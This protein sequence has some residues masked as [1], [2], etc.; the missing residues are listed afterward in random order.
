MP[1]QVTTI[2]QHLYLGLL[3]VL[4]SSSAISSPTDTTPT[5]TTQAKWQTH[6]IIFSDLIEAQKGEASFPNIYIFN[7]QSKLVA[8]ALHADTGLFKQF[9]YKK[10][11]QRPLPITADIKNRLVMLTPLVEALTPPK[12]F[13][14]VLL[15]ADKSLVDCVACRNVLKDLDNKLKDAPEDKFDLLLVSVVRN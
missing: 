10:I 8:I 11:S 4:F 14:V 6:T 9:D 7:Q 13:T 3:L 12:Q 1:I 15:L 2:I 5:K